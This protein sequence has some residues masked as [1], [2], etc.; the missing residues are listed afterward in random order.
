MSLSQTHS[1]M[2]KRYMKEEIFEAKL[3]ERSYI[4]KN[5]EKKYDW[6]GG[7]YEV[8]VK[9]QGFSSVQMGALPAIGDIAEGAFS[10]G[11]INSQKELTMTAIFNERDLARHGYSEQTYLDSIIQ[12]AEDLPQA[13]AEQMDAGLL[14]G[15]G[16]ISFATANGGAGGTISV[17]NPE[18]FQPGMKIA[19]V[20]NDTAEALGYVITVD[21]NTGALLVQ[22]ARAAGAN[23]DLSLYTTA[24]SARVRIVGAGTESFLDLKTALLPTSLGGADAIYGLT[25]ASHLTLQ[26]FRKDGAAFTAATILKDLLKTFAANR[27]LGR[28]NVTEIWCSTGLFANAS[29][30]LELARQYMVKDKSAGY[31]FNSITIVGSEGE[32]KIVGL[33]SITDDVAILVDW[34]ALKFAGMALKKKIYGEAGQNYFTVRNTTGV[35]FVSDMVLAGDFVINPGKLGIIYNIPS[36]VS[37]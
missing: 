35:Q 4:W 3:A 24:Q 7:V 34:S 31:G 27:K 26:S 2:L 23:V 14:R 15:G 30:G 6:A 8:P 1:A 25:K 28:G 32:V 17:A 20:D 37:T 21:I 11:T 36:A 10:M 29:S 33:N 18:Y 9:K 16:V 19:V 12:M 22:N 5:I 13:A